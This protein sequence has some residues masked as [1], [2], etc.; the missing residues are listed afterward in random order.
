[1]KSAY[2]VLVEKSEDRRPHGIFGRKW[3]DSIKWALRETIRK[4]GV[5]ALAQDKDYWRDLVNTVTNFLFYER[6][7]FFKFSVVTVRLSR[8]AV[9]HGVS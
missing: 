7:V 3:K 1:M 4:C 6:W 9:L 8:R 2:K 5:T